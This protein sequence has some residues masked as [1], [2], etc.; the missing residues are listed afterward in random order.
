MS[1]ESF[2]FHREAFLDKC[3]A[4]HEAG[5][6]TEQAEDRA[7]LNRI[8]AMR[9]TGP[10]TPGGKATSSQNRLAHGLCATSLIIRGENQEDFEALRTEMLTTYR[11]VTP[12]E[13]ML[14]DQLTESLWR[15]NRARRIETHTHDILMRE[16]EEIL[17]TDGGEVSKNPDVLMASSLWSEHNDG[18]LRR[19][20]RYVTTIERSYQRALKSLHFAQ[21]NRRTLPPAPVERT[22]E[23][24]AEVAVAASAGSSDLPP[25]GF[26]SKYRPNPAVNV[27][28]VD[29]CLAG[30]LS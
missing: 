4:D 3:V 30:F 20:N 19:L 11:P 1:T 21:Q 2:V 15:L 23:P 12:E 22:L 8:N 28:F 29:R 18:V 6:A 7:I 27:P 26:E 24:I 25:I 9:S 14:T 13:Q 16:T 10:R 5:L 17:S